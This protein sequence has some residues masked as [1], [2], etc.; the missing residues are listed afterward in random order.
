M[1]STPAPTPEEILAILI[2]VLVGANSARYAGIAA[3][4][5]LSYDHFLTFGDE[6]R[7]FWSG[8]WSISRILF[9]LNR[10]LPHLALTWGLVCF[11]SPDLSTEF[12]TQSV[13]GIW[14]LTVIAMFVAEAVLVLRIWYLYRHSWVARL[15]V[16]ISFVSCGISCCTTLYFVGREITAIALDSYGLDLQVLGC[17]ITPPTGLWRVF[18]PVLVLHTVLYLFTAYRGLHNRSVVAEAAPVMLRL[19]RDGG[20]LYFVVLGACYP[21][22]QSTNMMPSPNTETDPIFH[23]NSIMVAVTSVSISRIMLS[24][25]SLTADLTS[26]PAVL[27]LN[28]NELSRV[29]WRKGPN[30]GDIIVDMDGR[31]RRL[32]GISMDTVVN[33]GYECDV[34]MAGEE[35]QCSDVD[36][37]GRVGEV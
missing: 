24:I 9:F 26:D 10:Y 35:S 21:A 15:L 3:F 13:H 14:V 36:L 12:C 1:T 25:R 32:E 30:A 4:V 23:M 20:I 11:I 5:V 7:F 2:P 16:I 29:S 37:H 28:N 18:A 19:V 8:E 6:V 27:L 33:I 31:D 17:L 34:H 22:S